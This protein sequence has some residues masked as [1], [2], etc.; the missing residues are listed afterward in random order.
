MQKIHVLDDRERANQCDDHHGFQQ[1]LDHRSD[2]ARERHGVDAK[3]RDHVRVDRVTDDSNHGAACHDAEH[4]AQP[5][6]LVTVEVEENDEKGNDGQ[7]PDYGGT[8]GV[9]CHLLRIT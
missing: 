6:E 3:H 8:D 2:I 9:E 5:H 1:L 4:H 7:Q